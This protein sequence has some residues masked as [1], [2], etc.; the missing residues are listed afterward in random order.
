MDWTMQLNQ[1]QKAGY[2]ANKM[3]LSTGDFGQLLKSQP[4]EFKVKSLDA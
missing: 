3:L 4:E 2:P 1:K